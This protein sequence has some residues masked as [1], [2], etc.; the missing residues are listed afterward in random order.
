M[1]ENEEARKKLDHLK[2][3][4]PFVES[5]IAHKKQQQQQQQQPL[6]EKDKFLQKWEMMRTILK[7]DKV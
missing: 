6:D 2:R 7:G 4:I 1:A 5:N 3:Y